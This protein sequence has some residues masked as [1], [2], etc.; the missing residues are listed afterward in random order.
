M[1][2]VAGSSKSTLLSAAREAWENT[3]FSV[4]GAALSGIAAENLQRSSGV[5]SR[6]LAS[7][8][9]AWKQGRDELSSKDVLII[10]EAAM[11]G[12]RQ[13]SRVLN[14]AHRARAKVVLV[15]DPEQLQAIEAGAPFRGILS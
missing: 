13:M 9:L 2:G 7:F 10:D 6:T 8:E 3:G 11:V 1:V 15:G 12:T 14:A 4:K 5:V